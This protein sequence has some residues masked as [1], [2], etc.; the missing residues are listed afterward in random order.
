MDSHLSLNRRVAFP[1][2]KVVETR[3]GLDALVESIVDRV[4]ML[5]LNSAQS[6]L[7]H[8]ESATASS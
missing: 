1:A 8:G 3:I 4:W 7:D 6:R 2:L 5:F